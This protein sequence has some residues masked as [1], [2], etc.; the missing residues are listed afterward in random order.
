MVNKS[1]GKKIEIVCCC[2]RAQNCSNASYKEFKAKKYAGKEVQKKLKRAFEMMERLL[3][4]Y[5]VDVEH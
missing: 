2:V 3:K 1:A 4:S 5:L